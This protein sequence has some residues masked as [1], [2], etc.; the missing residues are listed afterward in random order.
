MNHLSIIMKYKYKL[1]KEDYIQ[2]MLF[3]TLNSKEIQNRKI[4]NVI[5][6]SIL[7]IVGI[8]VFYLRGNYLLALIFLAL[9]TLGVF[10]YPKF[11]V[12][13]YRQKYTQ[14]T[15]DNF[16]EDINGLREL[17]IEHELLKINNYR[18]ERILIPIEL[19]EIYSTRK[20]LFIQTKTE[21]SFII[22][23]FNTANSKELDNILLQNGFKLSDY[24]TAKWK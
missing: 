10:L 3:I 12:R 2:Y 9:L 6:M 20:Y 13:K 17:T 22:S 14:L 19:Q 11:F 23:K 24:S 1:N 16:K 7:P 5:L 4:K 21:E 8:I 15:N 18:I